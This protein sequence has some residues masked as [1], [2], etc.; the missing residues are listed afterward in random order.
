MAH[1]LEDQT[2]FLLAS[3]YG[4]QNASLR[5]VVSKPAV[6]SDA[7]ADMGISQP[8]YP[9]ER[10][11]SFSFQ[12]LVPVELRLSDLKTRAEQV[13]SELP[14]YLS[15]SWTD[16][17]GRLPVNQTIGKT[18]RVVPFKSVDQLHGFV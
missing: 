18:G 1:P 12:L 11:L 17:T 4:W 7:I 14:A 2:I 15:P 13:D 9:Q 6:A 3:H 10:T 8:A 16:T 5:T